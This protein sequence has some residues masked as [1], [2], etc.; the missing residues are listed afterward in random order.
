[1]MDL[2]ASALSQHESTPDERSYEDNLY[3]SYLNG[4]SEGHSARELS[5]DRTRALW[6]RSYNLDN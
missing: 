6:A 1:M 3:L 2:L 5:H 4:V